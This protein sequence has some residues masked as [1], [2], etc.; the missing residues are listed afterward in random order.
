MLEH[1]S[2]QSSRSNLF[3]LSSESDLSRPNKGCSAFARRVQFLLEAEGDDL[4]Q[5]Y[6]RVELIV[7]KY[8]KDHHIVH[9]RDMYAHIGSLKANSRKM[10]SI[11][12]ILQQKIAQEHCQKIRP[13]AHSERDQL[14]LTLSSHKDSRSRRPH[15]H[16]SK[17]D[18]QG[19]SRRPESQVSRVSRV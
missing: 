12:D 14:E 18:S 3:A 11:V 1:S 7:R 17:A 2:N 19:S 8:F 4:D 10:A 16:S 15:S 6:Q 5:L 9:F 13:T